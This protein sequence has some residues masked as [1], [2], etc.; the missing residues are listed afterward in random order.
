ME[1]KI[2]DVRNTDKTTLSSDDVPSITE[3]FIASHNRL[4]SLDFDFFFAKNH[5]FSIDLSYNQLTDLSFLRCFRSLGFLDI[6]HNFLD[7]D[8]LF[9]LRNTVI[10]RLYFKN[11]NFDDLNQKYP[12]L[13]PTIL[14]HAWV[15]NGTFISDYQKQIFKNYENTLEFGNLIISNSRFKITKSN[16]S[17]TAQAGKGYIFDH[18]FEYNN[19]V[20]FTT[21]LGTTPFKFDEFPQIE[22]I[23]YLSRFSHFELPNGDFNDY[24]GLTL[25]ILLKVWIGESIYIIPRMLCRVYWFNIYEDIQKMENWELLV[26]LVAI[27]GK[28]RIYNKI[29]T[30]LWD[31]LNLE[32]FLKT[33]IIPQIGS[34]PRLILAAYISRAIAT[35][36]EEPSDSS[37]N[38]IRAYFKYRRICGFTQLETT[39]ES[40]YMETVAPFYQPTGAKPSKNDKIEFVH[41]LTG[42]WAVSSI[43]RNRNG[44]IIIVLKDCMVQIPASAVFWDGRGMW[45]EA[46]KKEACKT[47]TL[48]RK[49]EGKTFI[50]AADLLQQE[51]E[52]KLPPDNSPNTT[53]NTNLNTSMNTPSLQETLQSAGLDLSI[54]KKVHTR[55]LN[56]ARAPMSSTRGSLLGLGKDCTM[57]STTFA[58]QLPPDI[59][60]N[61]M[62][63][64]WRSFRG[65]VDPPFPKSQRANRVH[66]GLSYGN[67]IKDV[68][69]IVTGREYSNGVPIKRYNVKIYNAITKKSSYQ[70]ITEDEV[71]KEDSIRLNELYQMHVAGKIKTITNIA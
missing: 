17:S 34:T 46:A 43:A 35:T 10:V 52:I 25:G 13:I 29:E 2:F 51:D 12:M 47:Q 33:G 22:R 16:H 56:S 30:E 70:W 68:V 11:N 41:P 21:P 64:G 36:D 7:L 61:K 15:I 32:R 5:V 9:D 39:I 26:V 19:G 44:R 20:K 45:R 50:T 23:R 31:A 57:K 59:D 58:N 48:S 54:L 8:N 4:S 60:E 53:L 37:T 14:S 69:N 24:F 1:L 55:P 67:S 38:D 71:S 3:E 18:D 49:K 65:I 27:L 62:M 6:S 66:A 40:V 28:I 63:P 42:E